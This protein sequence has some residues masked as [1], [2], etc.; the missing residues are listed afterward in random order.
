MRTVSQKWVSMSA[1]IRDRKQSKEK[2]L[3]LMMHFILSPGA[4]LAAKVL[5][6]GE[7]YQIVAHVLKGIFLI[8]RT[9]F[10]SHI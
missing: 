5:P 7:D 3:Q 1:T 8:L 4:C 6:V 9:L 10:L 2:H